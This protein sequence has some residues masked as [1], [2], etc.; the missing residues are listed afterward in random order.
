MCPV[1]G[2]GK[3]SKY[4]RTVLGHMIFLEES[5]ETTLK[6]KPPFWYVT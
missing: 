3:A 2:V 1:L 4:Y 6:V 5:D